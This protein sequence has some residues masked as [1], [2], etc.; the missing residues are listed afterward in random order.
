MYYK[1]HRKKYVFD[2]KKGDKNVTA[3]LS[4]ILFKDSPFYFLKK[5][6]PSSESM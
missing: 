4:M 2:P 1:N 6:P 5:N 3:T